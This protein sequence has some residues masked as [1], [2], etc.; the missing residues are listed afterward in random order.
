MEQRDP[1][2]GPKDCRG[3]EKKSFSVQNW[4]VSLNKNWMKRIVGQKCCAPWKRSEC[5]ARLCSMVWTV[6]SRS[7]HDANYLWPAINYYNLQKCKNTKYRTFA[8]PWRMRG[9]ASEIIHH[10]IGILIAVSN[11]NHGS[12]TTYLR[13]SFSTHFLYPSWRFTSQLRI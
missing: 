8:P 4:R 13:D 7:L 10:C 5:E 6:G 11:M 1:P 2:E 9:F 12:T 3:T